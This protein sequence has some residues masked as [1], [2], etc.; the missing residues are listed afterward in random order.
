MLPNQHRRWEQHTILYQKMKQQRT[1]SPARRPIQDATAFQ[2]STSRHEWGADLASQCN[3]RM[4]KDVKRSSKDEVEQ[5]TFCGR[6][7]HKKEGC[8]KHISYPS[9]WPEKGK[10][11]KGK[12]KVAMANHELNQVP[13]L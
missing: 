11:D 10:K 3:K 2:S 6:S 12:P 4:E 7:G 13:I 8:F 9:W 1:I 5:C